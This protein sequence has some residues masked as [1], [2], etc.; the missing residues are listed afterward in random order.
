MNEKEFLQ[1]VLDETINQ[2]EEVLKKIE[3]FHNEDKEEIHKLIEEVFLKGILGGVQTYIKNEVKKKD[4]FFLNEIE[5]D[6]K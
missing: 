4:P 3:S 1:A 6:F 5:K 2:D